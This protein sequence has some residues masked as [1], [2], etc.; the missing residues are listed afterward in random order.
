MVL[1][2]YAFDYHKG[3]DCMNSVTIDLLVTDAVRAFSDAG[4]TERSVKAKQYTWNSIL[5][6]HR[7]NGHD[8]YDQA[9]VD[10][11][12][13]EAEKKY[14]SHS[15]G[16]IRYL[17]LVKSAN[18]LAAFHEA[19]EMDMGVRVRATGL[20]PYFTFIL[21]EI[22][23][24]PEW[25]AKSK[26]HIRQN[27][28]PYLKWLQD[29]GYE[30]FDKVTADVIRQYFIDGS[31][32]ISVNSRANYQRTLRKFHIFLK[33][34]GITETDFKQVLSF[35]S[36][37]E[38]KIKKPIP[39][40]EIAAVL[41]IIDR[42]SAK[43][44]RDYALIL[45]AVVLGLRAID[46]VEL[47]FDEIDW[48][49]GEIR[50]TQSKTGKTLALPLTKDVAEA[51]QDYIL[52]SRPRSSLPNVFLTLKSPVSSM[53]PTLPYQVFKEYRKAVGLPTAPFHSLRRA[54]G[55]NLVIEGIPVTTV[56]EIL[57]HSDIEST[58]QYISLDTVHLKECALDLSDL[59]PFKGGDRP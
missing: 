2:N 45:L 36:L 50:I 31:S 51:L 58:K 18:Y 7:E 22:Q 19:G 56:A 16:R 28:L 24:H 35:P 44:K 8:H 42:A 30:T 34:K 17:H 4:Y 54:V 43:G 27:V 33:E 26:R 47:T 10:L 1:A 53:G 14:Q 46:I 21:T 23:S 41:S 57:G 52:N 9:T 40:S 55:S 11:F 37:T 20:N 39:H 15:I 29:N 5:R 13:S 12:L 32:R 6:L 59:P 25:S 48:V 49:N 38:H 3:G